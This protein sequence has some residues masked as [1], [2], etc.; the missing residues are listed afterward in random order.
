MAKHYLPCWYLRRPIL[1]SDAED[2]TRVWRC[3]PQLVYVDKHLSESL[4]KV[5]SLD[6]GLSYHR[7]VRQS[8]RRRYW[9]NAILFCCTVSSMIAI[10]TSYPAL[11]PITSAPYRRSCPVCHLAKRSCSDGLPPFRFWWKLTN[12]PKA[13]GHIQ[14]ILTSGKFGH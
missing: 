12:C 9:R 8:F 13:K 2:R 5:A 4:G 1:L 11:A 10:R 6:W 3:F 7:S 14:P